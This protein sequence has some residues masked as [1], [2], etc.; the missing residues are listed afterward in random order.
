MRRFVASR[1][2]WAAASAAVPLATPL[3]GCAAQPDAAA[4]A[5]AP[6][7]NT[8]TTSA[9]G[10]RIANREL[11][12]EQVRPELPP[13]PRVPRGWT[14]H[15]TPGT[16]NFMLS[17]LYE[18]DVGSLE[19]LT[20]RC[21][22][23]VKDYEKTYRQDDGEREDPEHFNFTLFVAKPRAG[24][25]VGGLEFMLTSVDCELVFDGLAVHSTREELEVAMTQSAAARKQRDDKYRGPFI[26][27]LD[28][29][30]ADELMNYLDDRGVDNTFAEYLM[31]QAHWIEQ[32][33]YENWLK[34]LRA[35]ASAPKPRA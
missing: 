31:Q 15:H 33:E 35:F 9:K 16:G 23:E 11:L 29:D 2:R 10:I 20:L 5:A 24:T 21:A 28:E 18:N 12:E 14:L 6:P 25:N 13:E 8:Q 22:I 30:F 26:N 27:E 7:A 34:L 17:R 3:R 4:A 19:E 32:L 1:A